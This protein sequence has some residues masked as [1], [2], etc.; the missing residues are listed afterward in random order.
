M[1]APCD[2]GRRTLSRRPRRGAVAAAVLLLAALGPAPSCST[3]DPAPAPL[4]ARIMALEDPDP[5]AGEHGDRSEQT[6][7]EA[8]W[9]LE[10]TVR[11][12]DRRIAAL[13]AELE[14]ARAELAALRAAAS[15]SNRAP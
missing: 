8:L 9:R 5:L 12:R 10:T 13:Q 3:P 15:A 14:A 2:P 7:L 1:L 11:E 4:P 6:V